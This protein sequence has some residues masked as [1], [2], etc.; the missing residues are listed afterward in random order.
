[1]NVE[2][3]VVQ[4]P[5]GRDSSVSDQ[6]PAIS[7]SADDLAQMTAGGL[8][9]MLMSRVGS[10]IVLMLSMVVLAR[11]VSPRE[12]GAYAVA[13]VVAVLAVGIPTAGI[14]M[15]LVQ[16]DSV[17]REHLQTGM[18]LALIAAVVVGGATWLVSY[19]V[20][21]LVG[22]DAAGLVRLACPLFFLTGLGTVSAAMLQRQLDFRRLALMEISGNLAGAAT[23]V[24]L[25]AF[26]GLGGT[27]LLL[28]TICS[29]A[30][31]T[32]IAICAAP[33]P[34]P[35]LDRSAAR[36]IAGFGL[37][38]SLAT[39]AWTGFANGDYA[40][41][42]ARL[43]PAAAG[44]YWRSYTLAVGYQAKL[45]VIMQTVA[46]PVLSRSATE[47]DLL[48]LRGR[49]VRLLTV[50]LFPLLA[51][52]AI[53]AP[54]VVPAVYGPA[55]TKAVIATQVLCAGG[56]ATLVIDALG[57]VLMATGR[58]RALLGYGVAH[59]I[60]Y[61][62]AVVVVS[63]LGLVAVAI[64]GAIIHTAFV[65]VAYIW[66]L[67]WQGGKALV[68]LWRDVAPA[69]AACAVMA[70]AAVP[71]DRLMVSN[72]IGGLGTFAAV[73]VICSIAYLAT[74]RIGFQPAFADLE[75]MVRRLLPGVRSRRGGRALRL[76]EQRSA[77]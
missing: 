68:A 3:E 18:A 39:I 23:S 72:H 41:I 6:P 71:V 51:G 4:A 49:M 61:V 35:R 73:F 67:G 9:W 27:A 45:S 21:P 28:G 62:G 56:A 1:M 5:D 31:S 42:A 36:D 22:R 48:A 38:A 65:A 30:V 40:V 66:A 26:A 50:V 47:A 15:S 60:V 76:A 46:F 16:R 10:E 14:G 58:G 43:G 24:G 12:F 19:A 32:A 74:L 7:G 13:L 59:F 8:P 64:A 53:T 20:A 25:A 70:A 29:T 44:L 33:P 52:L 34:L 63:P 55:W 17:S 77:T 54:I 75:S 57:A 37:P 2:P 11:I 69:T